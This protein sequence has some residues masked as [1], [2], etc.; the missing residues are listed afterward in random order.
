MFAPDPSEVGEQHL[1]APAFDRHLVGAATAECRNHR[2]GD[3][4]L[5]TVGLEHVLQRSAALMNGQ[6]FVH[7]RRLFVGRRRAL[8]RS[9]TF[10]HASS[11]IEKGAEVARRRHWRK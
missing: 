5:A 10:R 8:V 1:H 4:R 6:P 9:V 2:S 7:L 3:D 11:P